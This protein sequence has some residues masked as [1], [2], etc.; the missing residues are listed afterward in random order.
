[1]EQPLPKP[2]AAPQA[3][4]GTVG[5]EKDPKA[6][7]RAGDQ[8]FPPKPPQVSSADERP[9]VSL[10]PVAAAAI[11][12]RSSIQRAIEAP[13]AFNSFTSFF[14]FIIGLCCAV[15]AAIDG[16][17]LDDP[18]PGYGRRHRAYA[19]ARERSGAH[20]KRVLREANDITSGAVQGAAKKLEAFA[21]E[22]EVLR[23]LHQSFDGERNALAAAL[24]RAAVDGEHEVMHSLRLTRKLVAA[25][26]VA[27]L[28]VKA[29]PELPEHQPKLLASHERKLA[30]LRR[31]L[32][33]E[34]DELLQMF[35][36]ATGAFQKL[37]SEAAQTGLHMTAVPER[38]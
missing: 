10:P 27:A 3:L 35:E 25:E 8:K 33:K 6:S 11:L 13:L 5:K 36:T 30:S 1:L 26:D 14:L 29:L 38:A 20:L 17:K 9:A 7:P 15:I 34:Q 2:E 18:F 28:A 32:S 24:E 23:S 19:E 12:E 4:K 22:V 37:L 21:H 16:Y 31:S